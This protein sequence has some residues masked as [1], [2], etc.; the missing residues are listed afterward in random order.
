MKKI[1]CLIVAL[2][3]I[4]TSF[5]GIA[6]LADNAKQNSQSHLQKGV[7]YS[8]SVP[9]WFVIST[10]TTAKNLIKNNPELLKQCTLEFFE[11]H[12]IYG[13]CFSVKGSNATVTYKGNFEYNVDVPANSDAKTETNYIDFIVVESSEGYF[14]NINIVLNY[15]FNN[16]DGIYTSQTERLYPTQIYVFSSDQKPDLKKVTKIKAKSPKKKTIKIT[17][18]KIKDVT[19]YKIELSTSKKFKTKKTQT[20]TIKANKSK[21]TIKKLKRKKKYFV[22]IKAYKT[23]VINGQNVILYS[24]KW[25]SV[26]TVKTK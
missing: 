19:G 3:T 2:V 9:N 13:L 5:G 26:K 24:K 15:N 12:K 11:N 20:Y 7:L 16:A 10:V 18:N 25:S 1:I 22:R 23:A 8:N 21:I 6:S 4:I 17:W 14:N